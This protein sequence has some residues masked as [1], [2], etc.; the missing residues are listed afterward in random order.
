[1]SETNHC[2]TPARE[3]VAS[4]SLWASDV[5]LENLLRPLF[6]VPLNKGYMNKPPWTVLP[7]NSDQMTC[8]DLLD[9][10]FLKC[11]WFICPELCVSGS[12]QI[13][14]NSVEHLLLP[15]VNCCQP[16]PT[17]PLWSRVNCIVG[18]AGRSYMHYALSSCLI[19]IVSCFANFPWCK[20]GNSFVGSC[21][22]LLSAQ[23]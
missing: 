4:W 21:I 14:E 10:P 9:D 19:H 15:Q 11:I 3:E 18:A 23:R 12:V 17:N 7:Q 1:M 22:S 2:Q 5:L 6:L 16:A 8:L 20:T 13:L